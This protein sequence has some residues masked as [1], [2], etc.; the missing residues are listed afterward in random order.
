[1]NPHTKLEAARAPKNVG[2]IMLYVRYRV[3]LQLLAVLKAGVLMRPS[4]TES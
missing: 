2:E 1:M 3:N 4:P